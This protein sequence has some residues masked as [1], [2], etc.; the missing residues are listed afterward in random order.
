MCWMIQSCRSPG[1]LQWPNEWQ[2]D[3]QWHGIEWDGALIE[4]S[5]DCRCLNDWRPRRCSKFII[6]C[7]ENITQ[8]STYMISPFR[9][10]NEEKRKKWMLRIKVSLKTWNWNETNPIPCCGQRTRKHSL[11]TR[12]TYNEHIPLSVDCLHH[13]RLMQEEKERR[14]DEGTSKQS[15]KI[16]M[17]YFRIECTS[18]CC[19]CRRRRAVCFCKMI[20]DSL[21]V[22]WLTDMSFIKSAVELGSRSLASFR[23]QLQ[24]RNFFFPFQVAAAK[25]T[26]KAT[27]VDVSWR[28]AADK[29]WHEEVQLQSGNIISCIFHSQWDNRRGRNEDI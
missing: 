1:V 15:K 20:R 7:K 26:A 9:T 13:R 10:V 23:L 21:S 6:T 8:S 17:I 19:C 2:N 11:Q 16:Q 22:S 3:R 24:H 27:P 18:K 29:T 14:R 4:N 12:R 25:T 28:F 5:V